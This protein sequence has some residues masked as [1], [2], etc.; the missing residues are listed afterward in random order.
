MHILL[1]SRMRKAFPLGGM[2]LSASICS[3]AFDASDG[4]VTLEKDEYNSAANFNHSLTTAG[5]WSDGL[6]PHPDTNYYARQIG[7]YPRAK[8]EGGRLVAQFM[9]RYESADWGTFASSPCEIPD[10]WLG[11]DAG[12][13]P[14]IT[15]LGAAMPIMMKGRMTVNGTL[16][17]QAG[18]RGA[19][20]P[21]GWF[22]F[23]NELVGGADA[24]MVLK[25][26]SSYYDEDACRTGSKFIGDTTQW[27]GTVE[28]TDVQTL[29]IGECGFPNAREVVLSSPGATVASEA[30][31]GVEVP[32]SRLV[33]TAAATVRI[34][35][36]NSWRVASLELAAGTRLDCGAAAPDAVAG[37]GIV[38]KDSLTLG[39][40]LKIDL[41][42]ALRIPRTGL[43][44]IRAPSQ[45][46]PLAME[47]FEL[48]N[49]P[50]R[51]NA[52][53]MVEAAGDE[54]VVRIVQKKDILPPLPPAFDAANGYVTLTNSDQHG[55]T[56]ICSFSDGGDY[57]SG[58]KYGNW[59]DGFAP[60]A[61]T[62]YYQNGRILRSRGSGVFAGDRLVQNTYLRLYQIG[63]I[64]IGD[65][66][67]LPNGN[68]TEIDRL[69]QVTTEGGSYVMTLKGRATFFTTER[70][71]F[72]FTG[73]L[74][75]QT[76]NVEMELVG[77]ADAG[78]L[79]AGNPKTNIP[80]E[81]K[82]YANLLGRT[83][84]YHGTVLLGTNS[85]LGLSANGLP[86]G[87]V[88]ALTHYAT[89]RGLA[90][91]GAEIPVCE[92]AVEG[93][94]T[95]EVPA[96][97]SFRFGSVRAAGVVVKTGG[98]V[99]AAAGAAAAGEN[100]KI[101]VREGRLLALSEDAFNGFDVVFADGAGI[102]VDAAA[103][104]P[105]K[106]RG[107]VSAAAGAAVQ[108]DLL[109]VQ[110]D[111]P[112]QSIALAR[113]PAADALGLADSI[114]VKRVRGFAVKGLRVGEADEEGLAEISVDISR[115]GMTVVV[116]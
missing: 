3:A 29:V 40:R 26:L 96:T 64:T 111:L 80:G 35:L 24:K 108:V 79:H 13:R 69:N 20:N 77:E 42:G 83:V 57:P 18:T 30:P 93:G 6:A 115:I 58:E 114:R 48:V 107:A 65:W 81:R 27:H 59:S 4:Y 49:C 103:G 28:V 100:A 89:L 116:R 88:K 12:D 16:T 21:G 84:D 94:M 14:I 44:V 70:C 53:L 23:A 50:P 36:T 75:G 15:Q 43:T 90:P 47:D 19:S 99:F 56:L 46:H 86:N 55:S 2:L 10:L 104:V 1:K 61:G 113:V 60:H 78:I 11:A 92:L 73:G 82:N 105:F 45:A 97:N 68:H 98:G 110:E 112:G 67:L 32:V 37:G 34:P 91:E 31:A 76:W 25:F 52:Q 66:W 9:R 33:S 22:V 54:R 5:W 41:G 106:T 38:V 95:L 101:D 51:A 8:F 71:P 109:G 87:C 62:N 7:F 17:V 74:S 39:G 72:R 85:I 63:E 102:Q